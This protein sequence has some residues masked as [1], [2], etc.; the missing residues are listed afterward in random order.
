MSAAVVSTSRALSFVNGL[1]MSYIQ[2]QSNVNLFENKWRMKQWTKFHGYFLDRFIWRRSSPVSVWYIG[3]CIVSI[4]NINNSIKEPTHGYQNWNTSHI[5]I[6]GGCVK[7]RDPLYTQVIIWV[8]AIL[9]HIDTRANFPTYKS[10]SMV[11]RPKC[12]Q[13]QKYQSTH[14]LLLSKNVRSSL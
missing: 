8:D 4:I 5:L 3:E 11:Y 13:K 12:Y 9:N 1:G 7:V 2:W 14:T 6:F 10:S